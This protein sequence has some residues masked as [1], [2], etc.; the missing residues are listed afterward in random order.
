M[1]VIAGELKGKRL[2]SFAGRSI[3]PTSERAREAVFNILGD[4]VRGSVVLELFAGTG[5][6][7]IEALSRGAT[8]AV[9][10]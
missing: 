5:A 4:R 7:S 6:F 10:I 3:R 2:V 9:M 1:R 8:S